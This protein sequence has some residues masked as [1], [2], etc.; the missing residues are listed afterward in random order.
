MADL[1]ANIS[2]LVSILARKALDGVEPNGSGKGRGLAAPIDRAWRR[3]RDER[4]DVFERAT[5]LA[6]RID[7]ARASGLAPA[8]VLYG[9]VRVLKAE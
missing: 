6:R 8:M 9:A 7:N 4:K 3:Y 5:V 1:R 2:E